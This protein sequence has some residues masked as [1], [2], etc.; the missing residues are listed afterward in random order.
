MI[1]E[2]GQGLQTD[3]QVPGP[4]VQGVDDD[5]IEAVLTGILQELAELTVTHSSPDPD[6]R[7]RLWARII[8]VLSPVRTRLTKVELA[9]VNDLG[10]VF[11]LDQVFPI[12]VA[13]TQESHEDRSILT[14]K[15]VVI[16]TLTEAVGERA[17]RLLDMLHP[18]IRV[19]LAHDIVGS[20]RLEAL[21]RHADIFVICWRSAAHAATQ[22]IEQLRPAGSTTLYS[23]GK[24]SSSILR[25]IEKH[26]PV[27]KSLES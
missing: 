23:P 27:Y 2:D 16:Y 10:Q 17:K 5:D 15:M 3:L 19:D 8:A 13:A 24:G 11:G 21:A 4:S 22:I 20:P 9:L 12:S 7:Q 25:V 14:G 18:G 26:F 1:A 6:A